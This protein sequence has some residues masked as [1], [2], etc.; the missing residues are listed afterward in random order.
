[1]A[2][3]VELTP[4]YV[5][6]LGDKRAVTSQSPQQRTQA[7]YHEAGHSLISA[8]CGFQNVK[9]ELKPFGGYCTFTSVGN[10]TPAKARKVAM[11]LWAGEMAEQLCCSKRLLADAGRTYTGKG[12]DQEMLKSLALEFG[13]DD[14][15]AWSR[16]ARDRSRAILAA[17][18]PT[19]RKIADLLLR[20]RFAEVPV[21]E[22]P[23]AYAPFHLAQPPARRRQLPAAIKVSRLDELGRW[24]QALLCAGHAVGAKVLS[25][26]KCSSELQRDEMK[27]VS[28][29]I[30]FEPEDIHCDFDA[31]RGSVL[32]A[33]G[34]AAMRLL[35]KP[36][37]YAR[38]YSEPYTN[39]A[40][41]SL[42]RLDYIGRHIAGDDL[43]KL[44]NDR[45]TARARTLI[46]AHAQVLRRAAVHFMWF[47]GRIDVNHP[48]LAGVKPDAAFAAPFDLPP[49]PPIAALSE[50]PELE[51]E[52]VANSDAG[53][54][55]GLLRRLTEAIERLGR[56]MPIVRKVIRGPTGLVEGI[57]ESR[58]PDNAP[59]AAPTT[60]VFVRHGDTQLNEDGD[61]IRGWADVPLSPKG[62]AA[63]A[64]IAKRLKGTRLDGI[65][66]SDLG[67]ARE[68]AAEIS[69]QTGVP[70]LYSTKALRPLNAGVYQGVESKTVLP[71]LQYFVEH[72]DQ[73]I[74]KGE[75]FNQFRNRFLGEISSVGME[76]AGKAICVVSHHRNNVTLDAWTKKGQ[77]ADF[78]LDTPTL[79]ENGIPPA[80]IKIYTLVQA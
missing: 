2:N 56:P 18:L 13:G 78:A 38:L 16:A 29:R 21:M 5:I 47:G 25:Y 33:C 19:V 67:R 36:Q 30:D 52:P 58:E 76:H 23:A 37:N 4:G 26:N 54:G 15:V 75:S 61:K 59:P 73:T 50:A 28:A 74:P 71:K 43:G 55:D 64:A 51:D 45:A 70:I 46:A 35:L 20:E 14:P 48:I 62:K 24:A 8:I 34:D 79:M 72:A 65:I 53:S 42:C 10:M 40:T 31:R 27:G 12:S 32:A 68:T 41:T 9:T 63:A 22:I 66:T 11:A 39:P 3:T 69:R 6:D 49:L 17:R 57:V 7:A 1:M 77:P 44:W 80:G 60:L